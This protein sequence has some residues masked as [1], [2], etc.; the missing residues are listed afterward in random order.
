MTKEKKTLGFIVSHTHWDRAWYL[1]FQSYRMRLVRMIDDLLDMLEKNPRYQ[2]FM[3]DGQTVILEDYLALRPQNK[4]RIASLVRAGRL[5]IGP[6]YTLPDLF[7]PCGESIVRNLQMG[8]KI[9]YIFG[10][11]MKVGYVP[12]PFG[13]FAQL[14]QILQGF[15]IPS[16]LFMRGADHFIEETGS[17]FHWKAPDGSSV[18]AV[19]M[20][21]GY[22]PCGALGH[23]AVFGRFDGHEPLVSEARKRI[24]ESLSLL[25]PMQKEKT[26]LLPNGCDHMPFQP[27]LPEILEAISTEESDLTLTQG[28]LCDFLE[29]LQSE[30]IK[31]EDIEGDLT[32]N[33]HHPILLS[34]YS[35]RMYLKQK[36]R[37]AENLLLRIVEPLLACFAQF[38][39]LAEMDSF[40]SEAWKLLLRSHAHDNICGCSVDIV[41]REDE[42]RFDEVI[43]IGKAIITESLESLIKSGLQETGSAESLHSD[44]FLFNPHPFSI[45]TRVRIPVL[46]PNPGGEWAKATEEKELISISGKGSSFPVLVEFS[47]ER[48]ARSA[49]LET[50]WGRRYH[51]ALDVEMPGLSYDIVRIEETPKK[52]MT[53]QKTENIFLENNRFLILAEESTLHVVDKVSRQKWTNPIGL[54]YEADKGDTYSFSPVPGSK[55]VEAQL[56]SIHWHPYRSE[57]I[58]AI[59]SLYIPEKSD[60]LSIEVSLSIAECEGIEYQIEYQNNLSQCRLRA[61][62]PIGFKTE[63]LRADGHFRIADRAIPPFREPIKRPYPGEIPYDTFHQGDFVYAENNDMRVWLANRGNPE[64][65]LLHRMDSSYF[66]ITLHRSV[67]SLSVYG[68]SIRQCQAGPEIPTP[69]A[70][71]LRAFTHH[72]AWGI[73]FFT[74]EEVR[75][76]ALSFSCPPWTQEMPYL[77]YW[78]KQGNTP[79]FQDF[80]TME[81]PNVALDS[82]RPWNKQGIVLRIHNISG[83]RQIAALKTKFKIEKY[84]TTDLHE[85]WNKNTEQKIEKK[86]ILLSLR[87][88]EIAT[89]LCKR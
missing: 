48:V 60:I 14:P 36:N 29:A 70:Q 47:E 44:V 52:A 59:Y 28:R 23:P 4:Q 54:E 17:V 72:I 80:L 26:I 62:F 11:P 77:A 85:Q 27:E 73:G 53:K 87:P 10:E 40:L 22:L 2:S 66:A 34:V 67:G 9:S 56:K 33:Y 84:C 19:Y 30:G 83:E 46:F 45:K 3:L 32:G 16:F 18:L 49:F 58:L 75:Q 12:D 78:K 20:R 41:H 50:T 76:Q 86:T 5:T 68:G 74:P 51:V 1:P 63:S 89:I 37:Y 31:H 39:P 24:V 21:D 25:S 8:H 43:E 35:T 15:G 42:V 64:I 65:S 38:L 55:P 71:C 81:N 82:C 57:T 88:F 6:W 79:R 13:H 69:E 7:L 61:I